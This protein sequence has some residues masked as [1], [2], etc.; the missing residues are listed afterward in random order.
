MCDLEGMVFD[1]ENDE[2]LRP[3]GAPKGRIVVTVHGIRTF[4]QW[5][6][7][8]EALTPPEAGIEFNHYH[9]GYFSVVAFISPLLRWLVT[10]SF[11]KALLAVAAKNPEARLDIVA[12][13]FGTHLAAWRSWE[14]PR[15]SAQRYTR[16][17]WQEAS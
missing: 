10:R 9:Y 3:D 6:E 17:S 1:M 7:R 2:R 13:S 14:S 4:G 8:L 16:F 12:H 5:Q 11:R 15:Q